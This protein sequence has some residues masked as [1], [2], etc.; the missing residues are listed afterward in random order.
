MCTLTRSSSA[1]LPQRLSVPRLLCF[2]FHFCLTWLS[3]NSRN[4]RLLGIFTALTFTAQR[5]HLESEGM[6]PGS[7]LV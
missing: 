1:R 7:A 4:S 3:L 6:P 5:S 2:S